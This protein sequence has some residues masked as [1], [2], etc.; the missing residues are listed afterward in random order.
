MKKI[1]V[2]YYSRSG[3]TEAMARLVTEGARAG[4]DIEVDLEKIEDFPAEKA[5]DYDGL[6][7]GSP[8]YYG[9]MAYQIKKFFDDSVNFHGQLS[10]KVGGA[11]SS[12]ANIGGGNETTIMGI[13]EAM[14]I[15]GMVVQGTPTGDHYGVVSIGSPD[16]RVE[17]Q[18]RDL[19]KRVAALVKK[20][21]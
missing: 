14:L 11:F 15:H 6:I 4:S 17:K 20:I 3:N 10:G 21:A 19:G 9:V 5:L 7:I 18:C 1:A 16:K 12:A 8:T 2:I 13:L